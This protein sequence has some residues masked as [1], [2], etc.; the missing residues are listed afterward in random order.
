MATDKEKFEELSAEQKA[1]FEQLQTT[2]AN[3]KKANK[4][5]RALTA[6]EVDDNLKALW[7][8]F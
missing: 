6:N 4:A 2:L 8:E 7:K 1:F 3:F 5:R